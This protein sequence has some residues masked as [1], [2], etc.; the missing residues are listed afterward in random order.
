[1]SSGGRIVCARCGANNFDTVTVC[2]KC[3]A[4][5]G[6]GPAQAGS[7]PQQGAYVPSPGPQ[8]SF[9]EAVVHRATG[10][11]IAAGDAARAN[12]AA[13]WLGMMFPYFGLPIGLAFMMC[14]DK[15]RQ[16]VGKLCIMWSILSG[17]VHTLLMFVSILGM[18]PYLQALTGALQSGGLGKSLGGGGGAGGGLDGQ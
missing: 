6:S 11:G 14:D 1:M 4:Q 8:A 3:G 17:V 13:F 10:I 2:W 7:A 9:S 16:E 15:R 18:R 5:V 12:R